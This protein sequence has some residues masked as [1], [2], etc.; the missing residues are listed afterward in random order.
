MRNMQA[1]LQ[2]TFGVDFE[3]LWPTKTLDNS[4]FGIKLLTGCS[5][6]KKPENVSLTKIIEKSKEFPIPFPIA[7]CRIHN[8]PD[9]RKFLIEKQVNSAYPLIHE[10]VLWLYLRFLEHKLEYGTQI[11]KNVYSN[12]SLCDFVQR[13]LIK[14]CV[15]FIDE[16]D[17][18]LLING[19]HGDGGFESIGRSDEKYPLQ[20]K[21]CLSYDEIKLSALLS[22][23]SFTEFLNDGNRNNC[24]VIEENKTLIERSG[25]IIGLIG[26]RFEKHDVMEFQ[27][28]VI[29]KRQNSAQNGYGPKNSTIPVQPNLV[30]K[31]EFRKLWNEFYDEKDFV[32]S[33]I[34][35]D[36]QRFSNV[37]GQDIFD[38]LIMKKRF[39]ISFDTLLLESEAR[40]A[41]LSK[42]AYIHVVGIGLGVWQIANQQT[43]IFLETFTQRI[44]ALLK[45]LN[46]VAFIHFS[47]FDIDEWMDLKDGSFFE[48]KLNTN[49]GIRVFISDRN[50]AQK[51][52]GTEYEN[53]L[54]IES[55]AWDGNALPGNEFWTKAL[56]S[57]GDPAAACSTLI[58][59]IHN[60]HI[61]D[62]IV[63]GKNLHIASEKYGV[64]HISE[65]A[66]NILN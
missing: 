51:L 1:K 52:E 50:P 34:E 38:N 43:E 26:A 45:E 11:E 22:V 7:T 40:A 12:L 48:S 8:Q 13:L 3:T 49:G 53:C 19:A 41:S 66:K 2:S 35:K 54:I 25:V 10:R 55:Y 57:S 64:I 33:S 47:W 56:C 9:E 44:R 31:V 30:K 16:N 39:T 60:P 37:C 18:F 15:Y 28:I 36:G 20:L 5:H 59:E 61:N 42:K 23:S 17:T 46:H 63:N 32:Y 14:R 4:K 65:Y 6:I 21:D 58:S 24:G 29:S 62:N 27:D